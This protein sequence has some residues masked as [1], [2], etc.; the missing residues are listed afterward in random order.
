MLRSKI[1]DFRK[2]WS[3][4]LLSLVVVSVTLPACDSGGTGPNE[5]PTVDFDFAPENPR[6]GTAVTFTS[7][8]RDPDGLI[9]EYEWSTLRGAWTG[10]PSRTRR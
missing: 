8:A 4:A 10:G 7:N 9:E 1:V 6:A 5:L 2:K 3:F